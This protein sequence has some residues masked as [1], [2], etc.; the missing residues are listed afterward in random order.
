MTPQR[1]PADGWRPAGEIVETRGGDDGSRG[2]K[3]IPAG[4]RFGL[5]GSGRA[6]MIGLSV[7]GPWEEM[8]VPVMKRRSPRI[9]RAW[10]TLSAAATFIVILT[11]AGILAS[12]SGPAAATAGHS[13]T[14]PDA[15]AQA[16]YTSLALDAA[17]N[18]VVSYYDGAPNEDLKVLHCNDPNC[19]GGDESITSPDT[20]GDVGQY[21]SLAL[22]AAGN[23]VV[24]YRDVTNGDL[25]LLHCNDP[26]CS[27]GDESITSPD[28]GGGVGL[29]S[30]VGYFTSLE[31]DAAGNPVVTYFHGSDGDLRVLHCDDPNCSG[32]GESVTVPDTLGN[33]GYHT[34]LEL[35]AAGNPVASYRHGGEG[36]LRVLHCN[37]PDCSGGDESVTS[38][39]TEGF[40]GYTS[41]LA[42]DSAGYPVVSYR[43]GS[44]GDL[45][46]L[47]CNDPDCLGGDESIVAADSAG[48]VGFFTSIALDG[49]GNPVVSYRDEG[50]GHLK[51][52]HCNDPNC[53]GGDESVTSHHVG[54]DGAYYTSLVLDSSGNPVVASH[55]LGDFKLWVLH[56]ADPDCSEKPTPTPTPC[57]PEGCPTATLTPTATNTVPPT[58]TPT[59]TPTRSP[60]ATPTVTPTP[61]P[62]LVGDANCD[63]V[64]N[65]VDAALVLQLSAG[66]VDSLPCQVG[67]DVNEDGTINAIDAQLILQYSAG[68]IPS[69]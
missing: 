64:V 2:L 28:T 53:S 13:I 59:V 48:D 55:D 19:S 11:S 3:Q 16:G 35:D 46:V 8:R 43:D 54:N 20:G 30:D 31:L 68:I 50:N 29:F 67:G 51:V 17:G 9:F 42:L 37:D 39:D 24:S 26:Y 45:K 57:P 60:T 36:D 15:A 33:V 52:L 6:G 1:V 10:L 56:C 4:R 18:P 41:S 49:S 25:K 40:V 63:G 14:A 65:A 27:G 22:D 21:T 44:N 34:S 32:D 12:G 61:T 66:L 62:V 23:P 5:K 58:A 38:P 47:H 69:L 7:L